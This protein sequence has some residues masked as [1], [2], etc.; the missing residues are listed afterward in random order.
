[1][2]HYRDGSCILVKGLAESVTAAEL[3]TVC[4]GFGEVEWTKINYDFTTG[5]S[6]GEGNLMPI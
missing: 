4:A 1:M 2:A 3:Q 5:E 6:K